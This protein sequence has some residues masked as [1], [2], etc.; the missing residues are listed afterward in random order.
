[1]LKRMLP[2][3]LLIA[4]LL[5]ALLGTLSEHADVIRLVGAALMLVGIIWLYRMPAQQQ[6]HQEASQSAPLRWYQSPVLWVPV[7]AVVVLLMSLAM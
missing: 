3:L 2:L 6:Q 7:A 4:G 5:V 1:M